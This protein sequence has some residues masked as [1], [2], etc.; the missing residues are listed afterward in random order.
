MKTQEPVQTHLTTTV[1]VEI[2][3][4][5]FF[6]RDLY[7]RRWWILLSGILGLAGAMIY[8]T[9]TPT[10][11]I[12][13]SKLLPTEAKSKGS[14]LS[15]LAALAGI[16]IPQQETFEI[17]YNDI[18]LSTDFLDTLLNVKWSLSKDPTRQ[19]LLTEI[20]GVKVKP[21]EPDGE[22]RLRKIMMAKLS[23][24]I[25]FSTSPKNGLMDLEITAPDPLLARDMNQFLLNMLDRYLRV[26]KKN[27]SSE[28]RNFISRNL[29]E[30]GSSLSK[31]E[32]RLLTF[33]ERNLSI[34][35]PG[36]QLELQRLAS[37]VELNRTIYLELRK[38]LELAKIDEFKNIDFISILNKPELPVSKS[39][40]KRR[41]IGLVW[42]IV[43]LF[44]GMMLSLIA[45]LWERRGIEWVRNLRQN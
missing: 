2:L 13:A 40:P 22:G 17:Y 11:W 42:T 12:S 4:L 45:G 44:L 5:S 39:G 7:K 6:F 30:V 37:E 33:K 32:Q 24:M 38:Q 27:K 14:N 1:E 16:N 41:V 35:S 21:S 10:T 34:S 20:L 29:E 8:C 18:L 26:T 23:K 36:L 28:N 9:Q 19:L 3:D 15:G 31:A 43:G 25:F